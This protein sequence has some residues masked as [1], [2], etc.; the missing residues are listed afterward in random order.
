MKKLFKIEINRVNILFFCF[1]IIFLIIFARLLYLQIIRHNYYIK[2]AQES[3]LGITKLP[4]KRGEIL[5]SDP[6]SGTKFK[7]ATTTTYNLLFADP[8]IITKDDNAELIAKNLAPILFDLEH[9]KEEDQREVKKMKLV[10]DNA[11]DANKIIE[12]NDNELMENFTKN[13]ED[14]MN[15]YIRKEILLITQVDPE[16]ENEIK[17]LHL[18]GI[19]I[20]DDK[21]LYAYPKEIDSASKSAKKLAPLINFDK[22]YL[23]RILAGKNHYTIIARKLAPEKAEQLETL[24]KENPELYKGVKMTKE[25]Y[26]YYPEQN[27]AAQVLGYVNSAGIGQYGIEGRYNHILIGKAGFIESQKDA[28]GAILTVGDS[29]VQT[30]EDGADITLTIDRAIQ[31]ETEKDLEEAVKIYKADAG[32]ALV[33]NPETGEILAMAN[34]PTFNPNNYGT[35]FEKKEISLSQTEIDNLTAVGEG[36]EKKLYLYTQRNPDIRFEVFEDE[37]I[38]GTYYRYE[39]YVGSEVYRN[40]NITDL[41]EP[42]S[43]FKVI[44]MSSALDASEVEPLSTHQ[45][46]GPLKVPKTANP[47]SDNDYFFI[48]TFNNQY[49]GTETMTEVLQN[50]CNI[51]MAHVAAKLGENLF[52]NYIKKF[53]YGERT[54]IEFDNENAGTVEYYTYWD[55][56]ELFTKGFGQGISVTPIQHVAG[57][58]ALANDGTLM[59]PYIVKKID[60]KNGKSEIFEPQI[61]EQVITKESSDKITAMMIAVCENSYDKKGQVDGYYVACKTG[62]SQTYKFGKALSGVGTTVGSF[63]GFGPVSDPKFLV[64][65]KLDKTKTSPWGSETAAPTGQKILDFLFRHY[66]IKP[67]KN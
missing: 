8:S 30:A 15:E 52:Y 31:L 32:Q 2:I 21:N 3:H 14:Q 57:L 6:H 13:L 67:D 40:K 37:E 48:K 49:H 44:A 66:N 55:K 51:G 43:T 62:T 27:L 17:K 45:C 7:L 46:T 63:V 4:A 24:F 39:N 36:E 41:Y 1:L 42:G 60:Y 50:S 34:Y 22:D 10:A 12:K 56:S 35:V 65:I 9:E 33:V 16:L 38:P 5:L 64:L 25:H 61:I 26:R 53:G 23:E 28:T 18:T 58:A 19:R 11:E 29:K 47:K 20:N 59:Q 54:G